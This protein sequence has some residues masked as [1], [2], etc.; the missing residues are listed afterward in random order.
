MC[1]LHL[2]KTYGKCWQ[3]GHN[4]ITCGRPPKKAIRPQNLKHLP[5]NK[6]PTAGPSNLH[7]IQK[8][9]VGNF[10]SQSIPDNFQ[11]LTH[12]QPCELCKGYGH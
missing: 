4:I 7:P 6:P 1:L 3:P 8:G 9:K 2:N 11:R 5:E 12:D 10:T